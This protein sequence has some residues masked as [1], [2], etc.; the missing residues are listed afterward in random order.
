F[1]M[2]PDVFCW[3]YRSENPGNALCT[4][5]PSA[6]AYTDNAGRNPISGGQGKASWAIYRRT[7]EGLQDTARGT[8]S[9]GGV[10]G[11]S[12]G[13]PAPDRP[14]RERGSVAG[15]GQRVGR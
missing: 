11:W 12:T 5:W 13:N 7:L 2:P 9:P 6:F 15:N 1:W 14:F 3:H 10:L 4:G 8:I